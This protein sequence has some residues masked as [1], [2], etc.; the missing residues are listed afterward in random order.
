[1][2]RPQMQWNVLDV[3]QPP[4]S[5]CSPA[6]DRPVGVLR[7]LAA[8][9]ARRPDGRRR[10]C[11]YGGRLT[12]AVRLGNVCATQFHPEK[13]G[14]VGLR[15][16][17][18][19]VDAGARRRARALIDLYPAIDLR[20]GRCVRLHQGDYAAETVYGDDPVAVA[21]A[22]ADAGAPWIHVVDLDAARTGDPVNRPVVAAIA[23][24]SAG[25]G[26]ADR[27]GRAQTTPPPRRSPRPGWPGS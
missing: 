23:S 11:D 18:N 15:L 14:A 12:A 22:F 4:T 8:R 20:D 19:F 21:V 2:K 1:M 6:S 17:A 26:R 16:L 24:A 25:R 9:R 27:R 7:A 13:S 10:T 3:V 5:R